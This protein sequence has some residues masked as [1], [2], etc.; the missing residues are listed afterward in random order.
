MQTLAPSLDSQTNLLPQADFPSTLVVVDPNVQ[1]LQLLVKDILPRARVLLLDKERDGIEQVTQALTQFSTLEQL[2]ILSHGSPGN[3]FLGS[4]QLNLKTIGRYSQLLCSW[5]DWLKN[6]D[7]LLYGCR[8]GQGKA[9]GLLLQKLQKLTGANLAA[10]TARVGHGHWDLDVQ[11][12]DITSEVIVSRSL[13]QNYAAHFDPVVSFSLNTDTAIESENT[14]TV[15]NFTLSETPPAGGTVIRLDG[16]PDQA[17]NQWDL[18]QLEF[19]GLADI[20]EDVSPNLDFSAFNLTIVEQNASFSLPTFNDFTVD[21]PFP[22]VWTISAVSNGTVNPAADTARVTIYDDPS[23]VPADPP[24]SP[25]LTTTEA[26]NA[27]G[28]F[29]ADF[30]LTRNPDVA[31][32]GFD[33]LAHYVNFGAREGRSPR[34][35]ADM[36]FYLANNPDIANAV[37]NGVIE[38][39]LIHFAQFGAFEER[40]PSCYF[41]TSDYLLNNPDVAQAGVNPLGHYVQFGAF[42]G[43]DPNAVFDSDFYLTSNPDVDAAGL[44]PLEHYIQFGASEGRSASASFDPDSYLAANPDVAAA[45]V[46][47][48]CHYLRFGISEGRPV[49]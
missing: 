38:N 43:R 31:A 19:S 2:H 29:D 13:Q 41:D 24:A 12:G 4:S 22:V 33:P 15:W 42:E 5:A 1:D 25:P 11:L 39:P 45:G 28:G 44:N 16:D 34:L 35:L 18:F 23:Q 26:I 9:G 21:S 32:A 37:T 46:E 14:L 30:Y 3:V 7:I 10:A 48:L 40:D 8:V 27:I 20:P 49:A 36:P 17:I 6:S 47:A